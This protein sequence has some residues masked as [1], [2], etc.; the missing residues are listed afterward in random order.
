[1]YDARPTSLKALKEIRKRTY[2]RLSALNDVI[3]SG[4]KLTPGERAEFSKLESEL[5]GIDA[6]VK[7]RKDGQRRDKSAKRGVPEIQGTPNEALV[8]GQSMTEWVR[9]AAEN[10]V[11][12]QPAGKNGGS[13]QRLLSWD[14]DQLNA[15]FGQRMGFARPGAELR[16][17]GEDTTGSGLAITP[18]SWT[19]MFIEYLYPLTVAGKLGVSRVP[20]PTELVNVPQLVSPTAPAWLAENS[21]IGID[22]TPAFSTVALNAGG[23]WKDITLYSRELAQDAYIQGGLP[24]M[25]ADSMARKFALAIDLA[26]IYGITSTS[27]VAPGITN[28]VGFN[29]RY[30]TGGSAGTYVA[31]ADT[32]EFSK[33]LELIRVAND[34][35]TGGI[36]CNPQ[37]AGTIARTNASTYAKY[38]DFSSDVIAS[39]ID[40]FVYTTQLTNTETAANPPATTGGTGSSFFMGP[41]Q[42]VMLGVHLDF[43]TMTLNERYVDQNQVGLFGFFRG[44]IRTGHPEAFYRT[45]AITTS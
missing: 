24:G 29:T 20:M 3:N 32:T 5:R 18:Q 17:L 31:P 22:A 25:L 28:E 14:N 36:L 23:G 11:Q 42:R 9:R 44:S 37:V 16:A 12:W 27:A 2:G 41:W 26:M 34:A 6:T 15:Y 45:V 38:W 10:G 33:V 30:Y 1:M 39:G 35:P 8:P 43:G 19:A 21:T 40:N 13:P 4:R 7:I